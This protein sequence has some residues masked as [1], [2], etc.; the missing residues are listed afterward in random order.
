MSRTQVWKLVA[1]GE[2]HPIRIGRAVRFLES[3]IGDWI[4]ARVSQAGGD[5]GA[6]ESRAG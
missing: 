1:A 3:D 2:L 6:P 4:A 5:P